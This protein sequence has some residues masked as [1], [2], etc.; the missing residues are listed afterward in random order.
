M[1][2][3][4]HRVN[5][6]LLPSTLFDITNFLYQHTRRERGPHDINEHRM[7]CK[8]A[9]IRFFTSDFEQ[10]RVKPHQVHVPVIEMSP[11]HLGGV[12]VVE[13]RDISLNCLL[14][15]GHFRCLARV[16]PI[17]M[18]HLSCPCREDKLHNIHRL[19]RPVL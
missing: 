14:V 1:H 16:K 7:H 3:T 4:A 12:D 15:M 8:K 17:L 13:P 19:I 5:S 9:N 6:I 2:Y 18:V 11:H 10:V